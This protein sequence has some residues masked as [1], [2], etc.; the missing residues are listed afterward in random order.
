MPPGPLTIE[1]SNIVRGWVSRRGTNA[2]RVAAAVGLSQP[3]LSALL[4]G[5]KVFRL[6]ELDAVCRHLGIEVVDVIREADEVAG[7]REL[8]PHD[9]P[10]AVSGTG[11]RRRAVVRSGEAATSG[12]T[13]S[14]H[15]ESNL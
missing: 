7:P 12:V 10:V 9:E 8:L 11:R 15:P 1:V 6:E 3:Y 13:G 14:S 4:R 5:D 2:T